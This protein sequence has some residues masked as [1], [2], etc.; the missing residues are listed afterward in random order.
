MG[1]TDEFFELKVPIQ[2][3]NLTQKY[4]T[5]YTIKSPTEQAT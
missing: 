1:A 5:E 3:S 2:V 4:R